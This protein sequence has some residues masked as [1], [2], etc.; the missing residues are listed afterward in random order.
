MENAQN[1]IIQQDEFQQQLGNDVAV[2][3]EI[4]VEVAHNGNN[5]NEK[6]PPDEGIEP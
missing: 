5:A 6:D 1:N 2:S 4:K 3:N